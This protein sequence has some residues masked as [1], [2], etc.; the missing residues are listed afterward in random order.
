M[1]QRPLRYT[2]IGRHNRGLQRLRRTVAREDPRLT[3]LDGVKLIADAV[4]GG[5][6]V[7][8]VYGTSERLDALAD[9][10]ALDASTPVYLVEES[11]AQRLAP[12]RSSQGVLAVVEVPRRTLT[13]S[14]VV[15]YLADV[16]DPGNVG[17][18]VRCAAALGAT[19]VACSPACADPFSP[20]A[21]RASAGTAL[22]LPVSTS[23]ELRPL[24]VAAHAGGGEVVAT[25]GRGGMPIADWS[26]RPPLVVVFGNEGQGIP[27]EIA[28]L[29][30]GVVSIPVLGPAESLNVTVAA[31]IVLHA[32]AGVVTPPILD[33]GYGEDE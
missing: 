21:L 30:D 4:A 16:Q 29:C 31:G 32:L 1:P 15:V 28:T 18:I 27:P 14:G 6:T 2:A 26:P 8:E 17:G 23:A 13:V 7:V 22:F 9:A 24:A 3:V 11:V 33:S 10:G 25:G 19:G 5:L 20:K 12:T